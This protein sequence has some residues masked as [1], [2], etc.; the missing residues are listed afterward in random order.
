[1]KASLIVSLPARLAR[2]SPAPL[3][4]LDEAGVTFHDL[5]RRDQMQRFR[6]G[7]RNEHAVERVAVMKG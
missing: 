2:L 5:V 6:N 1:M 4:Q 3:H 7:L